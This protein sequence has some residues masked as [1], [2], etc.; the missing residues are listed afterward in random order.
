MLSTLT[1]DRSLRSTALAGLALTLLACG[2]SPS[3][4]VDAA[5]TVDAAPDLGEARRRI[6]AYIDLRFTATAADTTALVDYLGS[7]QVDAPALEA[8]LRGGRD[9]YTGV[10]WPIGARSA[11][12][13]VD[14]FHV[15]YSSVYYA[16]LP[17]TF[18]ADAATAWPV[19][20]V[21]H[22]GNSTM[23]AEYSR[24]TARSYVDAY[25]PLAE[26]MGAIIVAPASERGWSPIGDSLI[27]SV[28]S[29]LQ[30]KVRIDPDRVV[31]T[32]QSMGGHLAWRSAMTFSDVFAGFVPMSGGYPDWVNGPALY[33]LWDT[34]GYHTW[35]VDELYD[36]DTTNETLRTFLTSHGYTWA[37]SEAPGEHP[38]ASQAF[39]FIAS[40][41][42]AHRRDLTASHLY[43]RGG[44][45]MQYTGN[46]VV[47]GWPEHTIDLTRPLMYNQHRFVRL[48]PR[49][50]DL[51]AVQEI[52]GAVFEGNVINLKTSGVRHLTVMLHPDMGLDLSQIVVVRVN[53]AEKFRGVIEPDLGRMLD[54]AREYDDRGRVFY[55]F[56]E[57]DVDTDQVVGAPWE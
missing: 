38:I 4:A 19:L 33:N 23:S 26:Q 53:G 15:D 51:A 32:G 50:D 34:F 8:L 28:L 52:K 40:T 7:Q 3:A 47:D 5:T 2:G 42:G 11:E 46:W 55:G 17:S 13:P 25:A 36:L 49:T 9:S 1:A 24:S 18:D 21:G 14:C 41:I 31:L 22:G 10:D 6:D 39:P 12:N 43:F 30:R 44:G 16:Y 20:V 35:G 37:G 48:A 54:L 57:V 56:V 27:F 29:D 45:A